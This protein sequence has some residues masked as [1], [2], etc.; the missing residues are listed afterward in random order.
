MAETSAFRES[1]GSVQ[2]IPD[3]WLFRLFQIASLAVASKKLMSTIVCLFFTVY[4]RPKTKSE[5]EKTSP[6]AS[7]HP[8]S[9][10][11]R[12][13]HSGRART[14][15]RTHTQRKHTAVVEDGSE[16]AWSGGDGRVLPGDPGHGHLGVHALKEGGEEL[17]GKWHGDHAAGRTQHQPA[18]W[19][20]YSHR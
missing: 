19:H 5:A 7:T 8:C 12:S 3:T 18:R 15:A 9:N 17:H 14:H 6:R 16:C 20:L 10:L 2:P 13:H 4:F 1:T 11:S